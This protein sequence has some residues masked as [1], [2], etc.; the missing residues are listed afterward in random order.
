MV[1]IASFTGH[2]F[3]LLLKNQNFKQRTF[4]K[5]QDTNAHIVYIMLICPCNVDPLTLHFNVVK[6]GLHK[7]LFYHVGSKT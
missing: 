3:F 1:L 4:P 7:S 6:L 5:E 2:C